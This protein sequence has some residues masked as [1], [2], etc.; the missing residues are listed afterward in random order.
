MLRLLKRLLTKRPQNQLGPEIFYQR[1]WL[2]KQVDE[3]QYREMRRRVY[4]VD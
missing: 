1:T 3:A 4:G 2:T